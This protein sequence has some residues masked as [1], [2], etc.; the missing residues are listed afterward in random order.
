MVKAQLERLINI[1]DNTK[2]SAEMAEE[3]RDLFSAVVSG[4]KQIKV[5]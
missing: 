4:T 2:K 1:A 5:K 3:I